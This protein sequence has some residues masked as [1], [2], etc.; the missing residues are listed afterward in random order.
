MRE[1]RATN[2]RLVW[3]AIRPGVEAALLKGGGDWRPEDV[4][5]SCVAGESHLYLAESGA[6]C[7]LQMQHNELLVQKECWVWV[8]FV[9]QGESLE[10]Y[11]PQAAAF[12]RAAGAE[13]LRF[14]SRRAGWEKAPGWV[15]TSSTYVQEL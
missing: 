15:L 13:R 1:L 12:A 2:I 4:Y 7:I 5:A 11:F 9:P 10:H 3:D 14:E 8:A 6:F